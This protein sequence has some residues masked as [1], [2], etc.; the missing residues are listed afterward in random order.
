MIIPELHTIIDDTPVVYPAIELIDEFVPL[1]IQAM[2]S[3]DYK[4]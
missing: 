2:E 4:Q 1:Y 3:E